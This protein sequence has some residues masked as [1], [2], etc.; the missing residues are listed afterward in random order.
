MQRIIKTTLISASL[1]T[2]TMGIGNADTS[3]F[4]PTAVNATPTLITAGVTSTAT[5]AQPRIEP[6]DDRTISTIIAK[7][8]KHQETHYSKTE[9]SYTLLM[10][11]ILKA[12][13]KPSFG[14]ILTED[15]SDNAVECRFDDEGDLSLNGISSHKAITFQTQCTELVN[16]FNQQ[17][18]DPIRKKKTAPSPRK[19]MGFSPNKRKSNKPKPKTIIDKMAA[20]DFTLYWREKGLYTFY[21]GGVL[22][23]EYKPGSGLTIKEDKEENALECRYNEQ[24][25][26]QIKKKAASD[27][28]NRCSELMLSF[29]EQISE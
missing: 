29:D 7:M 20:S 5:F 27:F 9:N 26:L 21:I 23:A 12:E 13:Y 18:P 28:R 3:T 8:D 17:I 10:D 4:L 24:L 19:K 2:F 14:L 6:V 11:G 22:Q 15:G 1:A 16:A 25:G